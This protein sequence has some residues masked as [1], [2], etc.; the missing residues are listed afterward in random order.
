[1]TDKPAM[2]KERIVSHTCASHCAGSCVLKLQ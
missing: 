1:M 2:S